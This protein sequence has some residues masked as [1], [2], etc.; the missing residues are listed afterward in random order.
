MLGF[1]KALEIDID[2]IENIYLDIHTAEEEGTAETGWK[3]G[4]YPVRG[5][6][7]M[8]LKRDDLFVAEDKMGIV[9]AAI[10]NQ[11][12]LNE[13]RDAPWRFEAKEKSVMV[14]H[15]LVVSPKSFG[16]GYGKKFVEFYENYALAQGCKVLR[17]DTNIKNKRARQMY[18]KMG[19]REVCIVGCTFNGLEGIDLLLLEKKL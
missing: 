17:I 19:Y 15:T 8:A 16:K 14:L 1:R 11:L 2:K 9:G 4:V 5:T 18:K 13:Y 6:E 12:Q 3:R 7:E 10:I